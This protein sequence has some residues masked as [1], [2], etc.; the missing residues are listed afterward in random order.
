MA[1]KWPKMAQMTPFLDQW[2][3][4]MVF[5]KFQNLFENAPFLPKIWPEN[6]HFREFD[7]AIFDTRFSTEIEWKS[8][9]MPQL[10]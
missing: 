4:S 2:C 5:I 7:V 1:I 10:G 3:I 8:T 9:Q 6:C